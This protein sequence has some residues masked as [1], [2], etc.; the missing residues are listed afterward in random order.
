MADVTRAHWFVKHICA[1]ALSQFLTSKFLFDSSVVTQ[2]L[3]WVFLLSVLIYCLVLSEAWGRVDVKEEK[4]KKKR[5]FSA[6]VFL[7]L[8]KKQSRL[9]RS[10][11]GEP[12][13]KEQMECEEGTEKQIRYK[14]KQNE[15]NSARVLR[16][17]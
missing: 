12:G 14:H 16:R 17:G 13:D 5:F 4:E 10:R 1:Y 15:I 6:F 2:G 3:K 9:V 11:R 8:E 7:V